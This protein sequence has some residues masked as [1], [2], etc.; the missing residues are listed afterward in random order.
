[1]EGQLVGQP[2][3]EMAMAADFVAVM[4][5]ALKEELRTVLLAQVMEGVQI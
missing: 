3:W 5:D 4:E 1:M 2:D